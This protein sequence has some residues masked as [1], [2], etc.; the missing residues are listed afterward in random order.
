MR[1]YVSSTF[2]KGVSAICQDEVAAEI[3][4]EIGIDLNEEV[5]SVTAFSESANGA[6][7]IVEG[8]LRKEAQEKMLAIAVFQG[9]VDQKDGDFRQLRLNN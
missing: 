3:K 9:Q 4:E 1:R 7:I 2:G 5:N 6:I 8:P